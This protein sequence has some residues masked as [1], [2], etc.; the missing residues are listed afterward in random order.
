MVRHERESRVAVTTHVRRDP[1][2]ISAVLYDPSS[3]VKAIASCDNLPGQDF[4]WVTRV[5]VH[6]LDQRGRGYG[7][8][9]LKLMQDAVAAAMGPGGRVLVLPGGYGQN[10]EAQRRFYCKNGFVPAGQYG[11]EALSWAPGERS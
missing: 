8:T 1:H 9:V 7:S 11:P 4:W 6:P 5:V 3:R 2:T 10:V